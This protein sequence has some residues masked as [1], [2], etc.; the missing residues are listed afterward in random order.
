MSTRTRT[1]RRSY[2][3]RQRDAA[4]AARA[5][6]RP[7]ATEPR[8]PD[9][10]PGDAGVSG[11]HAARAIRGQRGPDRRVHP[12]RR[13]LPGGSLAALVGPDPG[14]GVLDLPRAARGQPEPVH[15]LPRLRGLRDR[16]GEPGAADHGERASRRHASDRRHPA[17]GRDGRGGP[18]DGRRAD[19][20]PQ[21]ALGARDAGRPGA[22]RPG[23]GVRVR[24]RARRR[25]DGGRELQPRHAH[26][27][28]GQR[29]AAARRRRARRAALGAAG[30]D[31]VRRPQG[32]GDGDHRR[33]RAGQARRATAGRS[34][35]SAT[36]ATSTPA[37]TSA[38]S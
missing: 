17:P 30:G 11:Q 7:G 1:S 12:R 19:R 6:G 26:R 38:P 32:P 10:G 35:G 24:Q 36:P 4:R 21:G 31:P 23:P 14:G 3:A 28:A 20:R 16:R 9:A 27:L 18:G 29:A 2:A 13:R 5:P 37:S 8:G 15:V 25:A 33:A 34:A 22:Q